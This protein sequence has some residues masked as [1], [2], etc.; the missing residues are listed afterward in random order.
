[1][2]EQQERKNTLLQKLFNYTSYHAYKRASRHNTVFLYVFLICLIASVVT[3]NQSAQLGISTV[4]FLML[5]VFM[6]RDYWIEGK[7]RKMLSIS[8]ESKRTLGLVAKKL[9]LYDGIY[10][11][12]GKDSIEISFFTDYTMLGE[13]YRTLRQLFKKGGDD[14]PNILSEDQVADLKAYVMLLNKSDQY[15]VYATLSAD[16]ARQLED[17]GLDLILLPKKY[18]TKPG[19]FSACAN[20]ACKAPWNAPAFNAYII[21]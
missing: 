4:G 18:V 10:S 13:L 16:M 11:L 20:G 14:N 21:H 3:R 5:I 2:E 12:D 1:M 9:Y 7:K 15:E 8:N 19:G 6:F 17:E